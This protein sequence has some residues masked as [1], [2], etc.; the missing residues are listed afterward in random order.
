[1]RDL[2]RT[3]A[4]IQRVFDKKRWQYCFIGGLAVQKWGQVRVTEDIDLTL[5]TGFGGEEKFID[6]LLES[7]PARIPAARA[8]AIENRVLLLKSRSGIAIDVSCGAFPFEKS[9]VA[10]ARNVQVIP[11]TRLRLCRPDDL[12]IFKAFANRPIDWLDIEGIIAKQ[13]AA[14]LDW[15]YVFFHLKTLADA[16]SQ[17]EIVTGLERLIELAN[18]KEP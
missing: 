2:V 9:A 1:M 10:R 15:T 14:T 4:Q 7:F 8:F 5:F 13:G 18:R 17:P 12:I 11:G 16:K 3:A 6:Q